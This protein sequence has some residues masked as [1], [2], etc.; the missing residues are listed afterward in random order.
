MH[1]VKTYKSNA[2]TGFKT[3]DIDFSVKN[4]QLPLQFGVLAYIAD[5][6]GK[7]RPGLSKKYTKTRIPKKRISD[8]QSIRNRKEIFEIN[9]KKSQDL[10]YL[11][12]QSYKL[13]YI[14]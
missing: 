2:S 7:N 6:I 12:I 14:S 9:N 10:F 8:S 1:K 5:S 13:M 4:T 11:K 3:N